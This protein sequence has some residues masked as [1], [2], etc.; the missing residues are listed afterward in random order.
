LSR[1]FITLANKPPA[2]Q[3]DGAHDAVEEYM[4]NYVN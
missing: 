1:V 3:Q 2:L 4:K